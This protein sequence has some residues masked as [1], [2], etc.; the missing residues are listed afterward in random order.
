MNYQYQE[1]VNVWCEAKGRERL[2]KRMV[3]AYKKRKRK[4]KI[5]KLVDNDNHW[6]GLS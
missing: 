1:V 5:A 2:M 6:K 4:E 3:D